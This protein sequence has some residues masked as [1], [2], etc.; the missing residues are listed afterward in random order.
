[1]TDV[2]KS[3]AKVAAEAEAVAETVKVSFEFNGNTYVVDKDKFTDDLD[4][5]EAF[6]DGK[7]ITPLKLLLGK[8]WD[9]FKELEKPNAEKLG[10][11]AEKLFEAVGGATPGE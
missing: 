1:M 6:E 3:V 2:K 10:K 5:L 9:R 8:E 11:F 4:I 7:I